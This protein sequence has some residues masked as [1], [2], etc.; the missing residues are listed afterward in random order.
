MMEESAMARRPP[1]A[2]SHGANGHADIAA[3]APA[4]RF[5]R[6][7]VW[8]DLGDTHPDY[9]GF[10]LLIWRNYRA[11]LLDQVV[12]RANVGDKAGALERLGAIVL[13]HNGW[14]SEDGTPLPA[15]QTAGFWD[16]IPH[17]LGPLII[18]AVRQE[19]ARLPDFPPA[20]RTT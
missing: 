12:E 14:Q 8:I 11:D 6:R 5:T 17:E 7:D 1:P 16:A 15:P 13:E 18:Q 19:A 2:P 9:A 20:T 3:T 4:P 10:R